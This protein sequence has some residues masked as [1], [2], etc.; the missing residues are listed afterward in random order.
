MAESGA[1]KLLRVISVVVLLALIAYFGVELI[2]QQ[3]VLEQQEE[4]IAAMKAYNAK[5]YE[6][7]EAKLGQI[8]DKYTLDYINRYMRTHFGMVKEGETRIDVITEATNAE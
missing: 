2:K 1:K 3:R 6:E 8:E 7:Y 5:L 4:K